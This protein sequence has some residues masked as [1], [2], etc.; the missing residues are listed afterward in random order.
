MQQMEW[1]E[2]LEEADSPEI[3]EQLWQD[4]TVAKKTA[5]Q[6]CADL[7]DAQAQPAAAVA[8]VRSLM[9]IEK[10]LQEIQTRMDAFA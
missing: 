10:L 5:V 9:F 3:L 6:Q 8:V 7:L 2:A 4:V 1:R